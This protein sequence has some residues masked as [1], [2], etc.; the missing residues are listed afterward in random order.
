MPVFDDTPP[1][2]VSPPDQWVNIRSGGTLSGTLPTD[3]AP[4]ASF[5]GV[6]LAQGDSFF[7]VLALQSTSGIYLVGASA[8]TRRPDANHGSEFRAGRFLRIREGN[9][10]GQVWA[11]TN[12]SEPTLGVTALTFEQSAV[13]AAVT[14]PGA[15]SFDNSAIDLAIEPGSTAGFDNTGP[16]TRSTA[17]HVPAFDNSPVDLAEEPN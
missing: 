15:G 9:N 7:A 5:H 11:C 1:T 14:P 16:G 2:E 6:T 4:G 12:Q 13:G 8:S 17:T 10:A 3:I